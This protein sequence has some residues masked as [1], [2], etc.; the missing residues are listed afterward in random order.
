MTVAR[1]LAD[2]LTQVSYA[3]LPPQTVEHAAMLIASTLAS[4]AWGSGIASSGIIRA[5][6]REHGGTPEA[7]IWFDSG[8][9]LPVAEAPS[10][11]FPSEPFS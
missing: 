8:P 10:S 1:S 3:D 2:F 6:A 4:A 7:S 9:K 11:S 5:L